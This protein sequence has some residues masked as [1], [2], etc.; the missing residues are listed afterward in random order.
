M[1]VAEKVLQLVRRSDNMGK[2]LKVFKKPNEAKKWL[3][4]A[5]C[6]VIVSKPLHLV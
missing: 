2:D 6:C 1:R 4:D 3:E 5:Q